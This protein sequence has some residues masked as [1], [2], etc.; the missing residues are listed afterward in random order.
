[1]TND[2]F[3]LDIFS[4]ADDEIIDT[5]A[6]RYYAVPKRKM[7]D[8]YEKSEKLYFNLEHQFFC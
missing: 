2:N 7:S 6:E 3:N 8:L 4:N 1:M 5:L